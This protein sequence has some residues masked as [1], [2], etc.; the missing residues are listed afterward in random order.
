MQRPA[1]DAIDIDHVQEMVRTRGYQILHQ[2]IE[3]LIAGQMA[4]LEAAE[5]V[6]DIRRAQGQLSALRTVLRL[7][8]TLRNEALRKAKS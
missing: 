2:R 3:R 1:L 7:P 8:D 5:A 6:D 4:A